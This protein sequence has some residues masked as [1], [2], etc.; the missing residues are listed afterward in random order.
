MDTNKLIKHTSLELEKCS[1]RA[2]PIEPASLQKVELGYVTSI[3]NVKRTFFVQQCK[4]T[5]KELVEFNTELFNYCKKILTSGLIG[6]YNPKPGTIQKGDI[7][8]AAYSVGNFK[9]WYRVIVTDVISDNRCDVYYIDYGNT[10]SFDCKELIIVNPAELPC[11]KRCPFGVTC[12][13]K[14]SDKLDDKLSKIVLQVVFQEYVMIRSLLK[15]G[16]N[17]WHVDLP[18]NGYNSLFWLSYHREKAKLQTGR[19]GPLDDK[20]VNQ[21]LLSRE[22]MLVSGLT[23]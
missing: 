16:P 9:S 19:D 18:R 13:L 21:R 3:D 10:D 2:I 4:F 8:C 11:I 1:I 15:T 5:N 7:F 22:E 17:S 14:D 23:I 20:S 6:E 12:T